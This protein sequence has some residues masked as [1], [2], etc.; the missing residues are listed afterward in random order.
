MTT[1]PVVVA[2]HGFTR[3][4]TDLRRLADACVAAGYDC[5]RPPL[6][7]R[8]LPVRYMDRRHLRKI[9]RRLA[10]LLDGRPVVVAGHSVG[11]ASGCVIAVELR[12]LRQDVRGVVLIDG[13]DSPN[14]LIAASLPLLRDVPVAAVLAPPSKCNRHGRLHRYLAGY[15]DVRVEVVPGAGHGDIE[16]S[17]IAIYRRAC[18]DSSDAA[19]A[20]RFREVIMGAIGWVLDPG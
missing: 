18:G 8:W 4:P 1:A 7:R 11:A 9:A 19:T 5:V 20:Q 14:A 15:P 16:G 13:V 10:P 6:A 17:D 12:R 2:L 3:R